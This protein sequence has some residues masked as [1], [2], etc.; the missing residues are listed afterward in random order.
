MAEY[1]ALGRKHHVTLVPLAAGPGPMAGGRRA[2]AAVR[3]MPRGAR[4]EADAVAQALSESPVLRSRVGDASRLRIVQGN[5]PARPAAAGVRRAP[6]LAISSPGTQTLATETVIAEGLRQADLAAA[7]AFGATVIE[8]GLDGK[9]LL[10]VDTVEKVFGLVDLLLAREVGSATPNFF[11]R[12]VPVRR[13]TAAAAWSHDKIGVAAAWAVTRGKKEVSVAVLDEGVDTSHP[14]LKPAVVAERDFIGTN[15]N[16]A[17]PAGNDAHGTAC[18]GIVLSRDDDYPG[19]APGCSLIAARIAMDDG[20][21]H[22]IFDD[23]ATADAIDWCWRQG[24]AVLNN[25]W[26]GGA[27]SDAISRAF[28]RART[29]GRNGL[30]A[31][32][33]IAA[34]NDQIPIDFPGDLPGYVT[35]GASNPRDERKTRTSSDGETWWGSNFGATMHLLAPGVFIWTTDI[36]GSSGYE[37][38]DFTKTFNGTSSAAPAVAGAAALM[39]SVNEALSASSVRDLLAKTAKKLPA[40]TAWTPELGW[41]RLD[42]AQVVAEAKVAGTTERAARPKKA[43]KA[44]KAKKSAK[45]RK[46]PKAKKTAK[47]GKKR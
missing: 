42:V 5:V 26:G 15:G 23:Y 41:G 34:G 40:Q 13:S 2:V 20:S 33:V 29:Q 10:R 18:A 44:P 36:T 6:Q 7:K 16:S 37:T 46:S 28:A 43:A 45:A 35:V 9:M 12:I 1:Q 25:S 21:G 32:V 17:M 3:G 31:V 30:G 11:R 27:P 19:I 22:W 8:E 14:S 47:S 39:L 38:G 4:S 24:A